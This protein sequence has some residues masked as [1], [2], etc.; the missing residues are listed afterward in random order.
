M[1]KTIK[2][3]AVIVVIVFAFIGVYYIYDNLSEKYSPETLVTKQPQSTNSSQESENG[4]T[5]ENKNTAPDF[6]VMDADGN[7]VHLSDLKGKPIVINFWASWCYYCNEEMPDFEEMYKIYG[8]DVQFMMV[9]QANGLRETVA[10][11]KKYIENNGFTFPVYFDTEYSASNAYG[12]SGIPAT[13]FIDADGNVVSQANGM[14]DR[15]SLESGIKMI[16]T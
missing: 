12:V 8:D 10:T 13:F 9:D 11:G 14:L 4:D 6:T 5:Q 3:I 7:E 2:L 1:K 16:T 15:G